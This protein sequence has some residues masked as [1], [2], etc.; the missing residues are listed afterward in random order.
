MRA[1][2]LL[3]ATWQAWVLRGFI[4]FVCGILLFVWPA[5]GA[6]AITW[7]IGA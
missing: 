2:T 5:T 3:E 4:S 6:L 7:L 1:A